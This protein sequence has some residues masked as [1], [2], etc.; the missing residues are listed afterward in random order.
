ME[1]P[2]AQA[3]SEHLIRNDVHSCVL[4]I[5]SGPCVLINRRR[6]SLVLQKSLSVGGYLLAKV[7][8]FPKIKCGA[9]E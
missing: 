9:D 2:G 8:A 7:L 6:Y 1:E 5:L 3:N 4:L